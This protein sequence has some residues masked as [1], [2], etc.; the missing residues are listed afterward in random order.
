MDLGEWR[1]HGNENITLKRIRKQ[2][3]VYLNQSEVRR[4]MEKVAKILVRNRQERSRTEKW[5]VVATGH[6]FHC[7]RCRNEETIFTREEYFKTHLCEAHEFSSTPKES[8]EER[9]LKKAIR[10][11]RILHAD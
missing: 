7:P 4:R 10:D 1:I 2:T 3:H 11:G 5:D 6:R 8:V 9:R